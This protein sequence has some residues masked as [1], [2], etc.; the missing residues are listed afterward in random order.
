MWEIKYYRTSLNFSVIDVGTKKKQPY[1]RT[2][3]SWGCIKF[4]MLSEKK[5]CATCSK[6]SICVSSEAGS[7]SWR[8]RLI[9]ETALTLKT[10]I[11]SVWILA[12]SSSKL[13][14]S[15]VGHR[16]QNNRFYKSDLNDKLWEFFPLGN[17]RPLATDFL[18]TINWD[19]KKR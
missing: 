1:I 18:V 10:A 12:E 13:P 8:N 11:R 4:G 7:D 5:S 16:C 19:G 3:K 9:R 15:K 6:Q 2:K 14:A 17:L